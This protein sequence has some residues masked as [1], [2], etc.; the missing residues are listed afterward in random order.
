MALRRTEIKRKSK[1][2]GARLRRYEQARAI[3]YERSGGSC[4]AR[5]P[6]CRGAI[7]QVHHR[8]GRDGDLIDDVDRLLGVCWT[9][10]NYIHR[11]P[12]LSYE[13]GWLIKR[14]GE[15]YE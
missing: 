11:N 8:Q 5:T 1:K 9:C 13:R 3:V 10:H 15:N 7:D 2:E 14:N 4:E 6:E 12:G